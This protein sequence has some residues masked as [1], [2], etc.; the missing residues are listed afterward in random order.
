MGLRSCISLRSCNTA[1]AARHVAKRLDAQLFEI[2]PPAYRL[3]LEVWGVRCGMRV[4]TKPIR[5]WIGMQHVGVA[6]DFDI[7]APA[8]ELNNRLK[9]ERD[10]MPAKVG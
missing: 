10:G 9:E 7:G 6:E 1:P 2:P 5:N 8:M 3:G 4:S